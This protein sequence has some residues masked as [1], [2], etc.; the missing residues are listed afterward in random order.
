MRTIKF[1]A[2][3]ISEKCWIDIKSM[4]F[5]GS[6]KSN[7]LWYVQACDENEKDIDPPYFPEMG[8]IEL[9]QFTGLHDKNGREIYEGDILRNKIG[10]TAEIKF[11]PEHAAFT[12]SYKFQNLSGEEYLAKDVIE[13]SEVIGNRWE[14]PHLLEGSVEE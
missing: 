4:G 13:M 5:E 14:H 10:V 8:D 9:L 1:R 2:W 11:S 6:R 7:E 12:A 3:D